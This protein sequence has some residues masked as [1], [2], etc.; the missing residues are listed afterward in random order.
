VTYT[1][2][3]TFTVPWGIFSINSMTGQ[4]SNGVSDSTG[5][6]YVMWVSIGFSIA[7]IVLQYDPGVATMQQFYDL[8][9]QKRNEI[10]GLSGVNT[11]ETTN[12]YGS[13]Y[14]PVTDNDGRGWTQR[15]TV[16]GPYGGQPTYQ[17]VGGTAYIAQGGT[18]NSIAPLPNDDIPI[19]ISEY[20]FNP[21]TGAR[22]SRRYGSAVFATQYFAGTAGTS[23]TAFASYSFPG[24]AYEA[25]TGY[26]ATPT[27]YTNSSVLPS[28]TYNISVPSGGSVAITYT[29]DAS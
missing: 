17:V 7:D 21:D 5:I 25:G 8:L 12:Y 26:P 16:A 6:D 18:F 15:A 22:Q 13:V 27:S 20:G 23:A 11:V 3:G 14:G 24:G 29:T 1:S 9:E 2:S 4:G 19:S 28:T 10:N